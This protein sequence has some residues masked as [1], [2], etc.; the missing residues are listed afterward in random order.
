MSY[1]ITS[2]FR[3]NASKEDLHRTKTNGLT[4]G[5]CIRLEKDWIQEKKIRNSDKSHSTR[6]MS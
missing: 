4:K 5:L 6:T 1:P 2:I 3:A